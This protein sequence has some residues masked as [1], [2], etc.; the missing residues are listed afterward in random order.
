MNRPLKLSYL[1][2]LAVMS[3]A[4]PLSAQNFIV[5]ESNID[6]TKSPTQFF[7]SAKKCEEVLRKKLPISSII[8]SDK[9]TLTNSSI[10]AMGD[11]FVSYFNKIKPDFTGKEQVIE[12]SVSDRNKVVKTTYGFVPVDKNQAQNFIQIVVVFES[13][14]P[15]AKV[16][17]I[18]VKT[19]TDLGYYA[20]DYN[21]LQ[22]LRKKPEP[23]T[24]KKPDATPA[25]K[26]AATSPK[27]KTTTSVKKKPVKKN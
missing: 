24:T 19:P 10:N 2:S 13:G 20:L 25:K 7:T 9:S 18:Q 17:D 26:P 3:M 22:K 11:L 23:A 15:N 16:A 27:K 8:F 21:E 6:R 5:R 12:R 1:L 4:Y 14:I